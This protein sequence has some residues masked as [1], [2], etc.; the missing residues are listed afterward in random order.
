VFV[1]HAVIPTDSRVMEPAWIDENRERWLAE[2]ATV[3]R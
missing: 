2:W 1:D 3:V